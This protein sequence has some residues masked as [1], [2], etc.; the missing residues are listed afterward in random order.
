MVRLTIRQ[1]LPD[2]ISSFAGLTLRRPQ[3]R[4][5]PPRLLLAGVA[6]A[7]ATSRAPETSAV[8]VVVVLVGLKSTARLT[9]WQPDGA[10]PKKIW[11]ELPERQYPAPG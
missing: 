7:V 11:S 8:V 1:H 4:R 5:T 9:V 10:D 2:G 3:A 6:V